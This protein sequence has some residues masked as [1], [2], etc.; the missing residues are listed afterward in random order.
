MRDRSK[1][2]RRHSSRRHEQEKVRSPRRSGQ[3]AKSEEVPVVSADLFESEKKAQNGDVLEEM[4][5]RALEAFLK[6]KLPSDAV[7]SDGS[8]GG[9]AEVKK[10]ATEVNITLEDDN[11]D[12]EENGDGSQVAL[13]ICPGSDDQSEASLKK[14]LERKKGH[15]E[16]R[17]Y[18]KSQR[19]ESPPRHGDQEIRRSAS[20]E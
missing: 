3:G 20:V 13:G 5:Q 8:Q 2:R 7:E 4:R 6:K 10:D 12:T 16:H 1:V 19:T 9:V 14:E 11:G 18:R 17:K 15:R